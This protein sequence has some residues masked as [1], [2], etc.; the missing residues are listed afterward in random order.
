MS[1]PPVHV[2]VG[3]WVRNVRE[4]RHHAGRQQ[5]V[6]VLHGKGYTQCTDIGKS[7]LYSHDTGLESVLHKIGKMICW[8]R[9]TI[10]LVFIAP[11]ECRC[12]SSSLAVDLG[13]CLARRLSVWLLPHASAL[14][15]HVVHSSLIAVLAVQVVSM[16]HTRRFGQA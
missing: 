13:C 10:I 4:V 6:T 8:V 16:V 12:S 11:S 1:S 7:G 9:I 3:L 15:A 5:M 2:N 14:H